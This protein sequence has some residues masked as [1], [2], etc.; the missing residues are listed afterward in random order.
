M[1]WIKKLVYI[2][3]IVEVSYVVLLNLALQLP[4]T[5][6]LI[7]QIRPEKFHISWENAW[8]WYPFR[9]HIRDA[10]GNGQSRSQQWAFEVKSVSAS[11][12]LVP[13]IF[14]RVWINDVQ[15]SDAS[16]Y[17]RPRLK[18]DKDYSGLME[19]FPPIGD[20]EITAAITTPKKK[21]R[22]WHVDI[23]GI[24]LDGQYNYWIQ[25]F[26]GQATG[27]LEAELDVVSRGGLFSLS[28]PQ[29]DLELGTHYING[30]YEMFRHGVI[31]GE[32]GLAPLVPR[33]NKGIRMLQ[34][35]LLDADINIDVNS[36]AFIN[37][38]TRGFNA[39]NVD[40][41]GLVDGHLSMGGGRVLEGTDLSI[42]ADNINVNLLS[43]NIEGDGAIG[44]EVGPETDGL[45]NLNVSY[46]N[47]LV[48]HDKD[49]EPLLTGQG[50]ELNARAAG[51]LFPA[52]G[53]TDVAKKLT[54]D[55]DGL[56]VPDLALFQRYLP[57]KWPLQLYG[58][59]GELHGSISVSSDAANVD[60]RVTSEAADIGTGQYRFNTNLDVA[61]KLD[62][63]SLKTSP[64]FLT[65]SYIKLSGASLVREGEAESKPWHAELTIENGN[66]SIFD[67]S[68]KVDKEDT[69]DIFKMLGQAD[70]KQTLG[71]SRGSLEI[72]SS[73]SSLAWIGV[74][75]NKNYNS[76]TSGSG[77]INGV[78]NIA[79]GMPAEGTDIEINS[80]S[81]V[82]TILDYVASGEGK[83]VFQV[84]EGG[85]KP[86]W[87]LE[88]GLS[89]GSL[90]RKH[91]S[92]AHI[93]D[94]DL[95]LRAHI[96]DMS[97][98]KKN[99]QFALEFKI[100]TAHVDDM[101][102][103]NHYFPPDSPIQLS[104]GTADLTVD[105]LLK[106]DDA[107][108]YVR[109]K[110][111]GMEVVIDEQSISADFNANILLV[112]G[113]PA[114]MNFDISGSELRLDNVRV[115]GE[116]ESFNEKNWAVVLTLPQAEATWS[117][118]LLLKAKANFS[119][120]DS[121]PIVAMMGNQKERPKWVTNMLT[122]EDVEGKV[123]L[124]AANSQ[125]VIP[126]A[127]IDSDNIDF[128]A[129]GVIDEDTRNGVIYARYK[130][131][132][133]VVKI[134]DGKKKI[135]LIRPKQKFEEYPPQK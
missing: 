22:A 104:K 70:A 111:D 121:R 134:S 101:S 47:L 135:D 68:E 83:V 36:L 122:I 94:V 133:L 30:N 31:S 87:L 55:I 100:P 81:M 41:T 11:I 19:Y 14:K 129:K 76:S 8:T 93:Q 17:Q 65:G 79:S 49:V 59:D 72:E 53:D 119:M 13:L 71:G 98:E 82:M 105:I 27:S 85:E 1:S 5:Q 4:L 113:V 123:E 96:E 48:R 127:F 80:D 86:D 52:E 62:N 67:S 132:D 61:L 73:V 109:L 64:T 91:E 131:L 3:L 24:E 21:K 12:D 74:L 42:D 126:Y 112:D 18:P 57:E 54:L 97:F 124:Q 25:Q 69:I 6:T 125:I 37:L 16:Y 118:P 116:N 117:D 50:L 130:K 102:I 114:D 45:L 32:L 63:P 107:D 110:A 95:M 34:Y 66:F 40:G 9:I 35:I 15:V 106:H 46:K 99:R 28:I 92:T 88:V 44:I 103:F 10:S 33:E 78:L 23:E 58:G 26:K 60:V 90:K 120:T 128:G 84:E 56:S 75:L 2:V 89:D 20:R 38:F 43:H 29:I 51:N 7:N 115:I 39:M 108:G 77:T